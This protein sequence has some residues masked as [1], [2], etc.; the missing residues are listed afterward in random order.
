MTEYKAEDLVKMIKNKYS[1]DLYVVLEQV[2]DAT[3]FPQGRWIDAAVFSL[4][5]SV[6]LFRAAFEIKV[7][8]TD[9]IH[10]L[11]HPGKSQWCKESFHQFWFVAP[12]EVIKEGEL[13]EGVGWMYPHGDKLCI[14]K[15]CTV[16]AN[17]KLN[18]ALLAAFMR[19]AGKA[20]TGAGKQN[21]K[22]VLE[23][24]CEYKRAL[25]YVKAVEIF[26]NRRKIYS[27][28]GRINAADIIQ[29]LE[30]ATQNKQVK[31]D[32][33]HLQIITESFRDKV[34]SLFTLYALVAHKSILAC[35]E[36]GN[37]VVETF[38]SERNALPILKEHEQEIQE[39]IRNLGNQK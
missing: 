20:I 13:P 35:D 18:D 16:N 34:T 33:A 21:A 9:F 25:E 15:H 7:S 38:D 27:D 17:P 30:S 26:Y 8:R 10:E 6:G 4:W 29:A 37:R 19:A 36:M 28:S 1:G 31:A 14:K 2:P 11:Q 5:P 32:L 12:Q 22:D 39:F 23:S 3:G 24:S